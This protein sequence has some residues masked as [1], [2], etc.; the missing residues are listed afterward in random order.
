MIP[1]KAYFPAFYGTVVPED[2]L[3]AWE[4]FS[5]HTNNTTVKGK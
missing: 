2:M 3:A 1:S 4:K 5:S